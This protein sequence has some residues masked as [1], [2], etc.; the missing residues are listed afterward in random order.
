LAF[1]LKKS[2]Y[3]QLGVRKAISDRINRDL[4]V[5]SLANVFRP[6]QSFLPDG[7]IHLGKFRIGQKPDPKGE[8]FDLKS[9]D[10]KLHFYTDENQSLLAQNLQ[11]Q[12]KESLGVELSLY[13]EEWKTYLGKI[14]NNPPG[15][16]RIGWMSLFPDPIFLLSLFT[17]DSAF[18]VVGFS[19]EN[20]DR[21]IQEI[22]SY[23]QG[24]KRSRLIDRALSLLLVKNVVII[25][26]CQGA[27]N[28][29]VHSKVKQFPL[30]SMARMRFL[31]TMVD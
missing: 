30:N 21:L 8:T 29:L 26:L 4:V 22:G 12:F 17:S 18:N 24:E 7:L 1:N 31:K 9:E 27:R 2:P 16:Y 5:R 14:N 6:A 11:W 25:P 23:P 13:N 19:D 28:Y 3:N 20:Y 10:L 15:M